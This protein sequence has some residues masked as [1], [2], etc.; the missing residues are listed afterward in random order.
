MLTTFPLICES[1]PLTTCLSICAYSTPRSNPFMAKTPISPGKSSHS[2]RPT[3]DGLA[4]LREGMG[5]M[6]ITS[7]GGSID[8]SSS[9][10]PTRDGKDGSG[11]E[12]SQP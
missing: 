4:A 5:R 6:D 12:V 8:L 3:D 7:R 2:R 10:A 11:R 1:A 9:I